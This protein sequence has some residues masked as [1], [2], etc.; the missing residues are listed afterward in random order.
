MV[1]TLSYVTLELEFHEAMVEIYRR[2][3]SELNYTARYF[4]DM[5][6]NN[7]GREAARYLLDTKEP[8]DGYVV[9]WENGRLDLIVEAEVLRP[10][11][12]PL[13]G[14]EPG[15]D[16]PGRD[17]AVRVTRLLHA[18]PRLH[19]RSPRLYRTLP[20]ID[21]GASSTRGTGRTPRSPDGRFGAGMRRPSLVRHPVKLL[22][23]AGLGPDSE[24]ESGQSHQRN[25]SRGES[26]SRMQLKSL[27]AARCSRA[28]VTT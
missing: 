11:V 19:I 27:V 8:S 5:V 24:P 12:A 23:A 28:F 13:R 7:G 2:A 14:A 15:G 6:S 22:T 25:G 1:A 4:I 21:T 3:K 9:L 18:G 26:P 20:L 16:F 10:R 17:R